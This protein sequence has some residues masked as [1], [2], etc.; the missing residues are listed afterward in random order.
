[1]SRHGKIAHLPGNVRAE[2]NQRMDNGEEGTTLLPWLNALPEVQ[3]SLK[4]HFDGVPISKQNLSEWHQG[5][6]REWQVRDELIVQ[7]RQLSDSADEM[8]EYVDTP[9]LAGQLAAVL[10]ARYAAL[11]NSWDGEVEPQFVEKVRLLRALNQDIALLQKTMHQASRQKREHEQ[12]EEDREKR[13]IEEVK[14]ETVAPIWAKLESDQLEGILGGGER[15][16][17]LAEVITAVKYDL[18]KPEGWDE[19]KRQ[20]DESRSRQAQSQPRSQ[21]K[22]KPVQP[23]PDL[24]AGRTPD[25]ASEGPSP[26]R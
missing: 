11:L 2:L 15:G 10:A 26:M 18:P 1:M 9:L 3:K 6:F 24:E 4:E 14:R 21:T 16:R 19:W 20:K 7:A 12:A 13:I 8:E 25:S 17:K 5:G 22:S 23:S